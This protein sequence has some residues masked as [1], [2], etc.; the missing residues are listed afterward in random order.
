MLVL[1]KSVGLM[2]EVVSR[3]FNDPREINA[4]GT[5]IVL[6]FSVENEFVMCA[7]VKKIKYYNEVRPSA[8]ALIMHAALIINDPLINFISRRLRSTVAAYPDVFSL[9]RAGCSKI[10]V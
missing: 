5:I 2:D 4:R 9:S 3:T 10:S 1:S 7:Y 8:G 6:F